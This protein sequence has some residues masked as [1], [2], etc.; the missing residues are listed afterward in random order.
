MC[1]RVFAFSFLAVILWTVTADAQQTRSP[2]NL[3]AKNGGFELPS[4]GTQPPDWDP[5]WS[6]STGG[7]SGQMDTATFH[8][9]AHSYRVVST[10]SLDW[11][12]SN[13]NQLPVPAD[14][15]LTIGAWVKCDSVADAEIGVV[16]RSSDGQTVNWM[17]GRADCGG[18]HNW[19]FVHRTFGVT[20]ETSTIQFRL[21]GSGPGTIWI[22]D[23]AVSISQLAIKSTEG[24][25]PIRLTGGGMSVLID[26]SRNG[27]M[28]VAMRK[29]PHVWRQTTATDMTVVALRKTDVSTVRL[30]FV[31]RI[32]GAEYAAV[33]YVDGKGATIDEKIS[34]DPQKEID[35]P[36]AYPP[37][38]ETSPGEALVIPTNEGLLYPVDDPSVDAA[39]Y[40]LYQGHG[41]LCMAWFGQEN[42][43]DGSGVVAI[44]STPDDATLLMHRPNDKPSQTLNNQISWEGSHGKWAYDRRIEYR[45]FE[46]GGY[47]AQAKAYRLY[48]QSIGLVK[49][50]AQKRAENPNVD[51]LIG[52]A[53]IWDWD[54]GHA[55]QQAQE[56][57]DA[58]MDRLLWA[59]EESAE[60]IDKINQLGFLSSRYDIYQ[61]EYDPSAP[62]WDPKGDD[63]PDDLI[64]D[65]NG[66]HVV[67]WIDYQTSPDGKK[68]AYTAYACCSIPGLARAK[69][70]IPTELKTKHYTCRFIDTITASPWRE[71]YCPA[72]PTTRT[73]DKQTKMRLLNFVSSAEHLVTG[74]ETGIDCAVPYEDYFEGMMSL[75]HYRLPDSGYKIG[76]YQT[77][78]PDFMKFQIGVGYR[79]PLFELVYHDCMVDTWYWGDASNQEPEVWRQR[80]L[81][82]VLYGTSPI[83]ILD[84]AKWESEKVRLVQSYKDVSGADRAVAYAQMVSHSFLTADHTVQRTRWSNGKVIT[85]NFGDKPYT[86]VKM[87]D[88]F[89]YDITLSTSSR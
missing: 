58:G 20:A 57:K 36:V 51:K 3:I 46:S 77:P 4:N 17:A 15:L 28:T 65:K 82:N 72:H 48:A 89:G 18:S 26:P 37:A 23:A 16:E 85:V 13:T 81:W 68:V 38:F 8:S 86:G 22:D 31:N 62:A 9:G 88:P 64:V 83:Y 66:N 21:T 41:G 54:S 10:S 1:F 75:S 55:Q 7:A 56:F 14:S 40:E 11:S 27:A 73:I 25:L 32:D 6:R 71:C 29:S 19:S 2:V 84:S 24:L 43:A 67:S 50:L 76:V 52:A 79:I 59:N 42:L 61:D 63:W 53:D 80:D 47:V 87:I 49:T 30:N 12:F 5:V 35:E 33:I 69:R 60:T 70:V 39:D 44:V 34:A 78:T 45:F 74:S